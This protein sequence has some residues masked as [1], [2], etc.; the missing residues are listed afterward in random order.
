[1]TCL[2]CVK[3]RLSLNWITVEAKFSRET[4]LPKHDSVPQPG[5]V[6]VPPKLNANNGRPLEVTPLMPRPSASCP[7]EPP[8]EM[9]LLTKAIQLKPT[10]ASFTRLG[11]NVCV[12]LTRLFFKWATFVLS[13]ASDQVLDA[14]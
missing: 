9:L 1:M 2:P 3:M 14:G 10:R 8:K 12:Q 5:W 11:E 13:P 7:V 4:A 6:M